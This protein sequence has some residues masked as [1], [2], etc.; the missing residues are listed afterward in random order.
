MHKKSI[1]CHIG[2]LNVCFK[3]WLFLCFINQ[4]RISKNNEGNQNKYFCIWSEWSLRYSTRKGLCLHSASV[5][6]ALESDTPVLSLPYCTWPSWVLSPV[7]QL[8]LSQCPRPFTRCLW[9]PARQ[10]H[11]VENTVSAGLRWVLFLLGSF[12]SRHFGYHS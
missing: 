6:P 5:T 3:C 1:I 11:V 12:L 8:T 4:N 10:P 9:P 7:T 2:V